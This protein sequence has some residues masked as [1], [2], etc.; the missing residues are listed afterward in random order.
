MVMSTDG[1]LSF[2]TFLYDD[3]QW[4]YGTKYNAYAFAGMQLGEDLNDNVVLPGSGTD[5]IRNL[6]TTSNVGV[7]G[8]WIYRVD[9]FGIISPPGLP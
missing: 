6:T 1:A 9:S 8:I 5:D 3:I 4:T 7:P 2:V